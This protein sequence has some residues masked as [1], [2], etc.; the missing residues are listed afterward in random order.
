M[1]TLIIASP[2]AL[3]TGDTRDRP[4]WRPPA[5]PGRQT[6]PA[7]RQ[8]T[9]ASIDPPL[10]ARLDD[11]PIILF[12][13]A[14]LGGE[15]FRRSFIR[16]KL[17][18]FHFRNLIPFRIIAQAVRHRDAEDGTAGL[19]VAFERITMFAADMDGVESHVP[20]SSSICAQIRAASTC[21]SLR[22]TGESAGDIPASWCGRLA[23]D[24]MVDPVQ[25]AS[26]CLQ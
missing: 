23:K 15:R 9:C 3:R 19:R 12:V 13:L 11:E 17:L 25:G 10:R 24:A 8:R 26:K 21:D 18:Q 7:H 16:Q 2:Y 6:M 14:A 5:A 20:F 1:R 4:A 22:C